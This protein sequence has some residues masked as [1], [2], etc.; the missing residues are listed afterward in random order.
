MVCLVAVVS[1]AC[2]EYAVRGGGKLFVGL[3]H[4]IIAGMAGSRIHDILVGNPLGKLALQ[5]V[6][7]YGTA[8]YGSLL[9]TMLYVFHLCG[10]I[11]LYRKIK[12]KRMKGIGFYRVISV[13]I[14]CIAMGIFAAECF[15]MFDPF[16]AIVHFPIRIAPITAA[17]VW[18]IL[19]AVISSLVFSIYFR[20]SE[21]AKVYFGSKQ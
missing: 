12:A 5:D 19:D 3:D 1:T 4:F 18:L 7:F 6:L 17:T 11:V 16:F 14:S 21:R 20:T 2:F 9:V 8:S 13:I 10:S 15:L